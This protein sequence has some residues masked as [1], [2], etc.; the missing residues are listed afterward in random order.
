VNVGFWPS[1]LRL[2]LVPGFIENLAGGN[3]TKQGRIW[4]FGGEVLQSDD[5]GLG[6]R[7]GADSI[8]GTPEATFDPTCAMAISKP[9]PGGADR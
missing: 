8:G 6:R 9:G 1:K 7:S 4:F 5:I 2:D 3:H